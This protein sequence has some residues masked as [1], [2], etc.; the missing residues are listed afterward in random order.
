MTQSAS[1]ECDTSEIQA[2]VVEVLPRLGLAWLQD[3]DNRQWAV[4]RST[5]GV[6]LDALLPGSKLRLEVCCHAGVWLAQ[7]CH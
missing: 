4:T 3:S 7:A 1:S 2:T 6:S 5:P